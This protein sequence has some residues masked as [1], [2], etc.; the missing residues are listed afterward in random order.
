MQPSQQV[1]QFSRFVQERLHGFYGRFAFCSGFRRTIAIKM[2]G[3]AAQ[4]CCQKFYFF[5]TDSTVH[6]VH[7]QEFVRMM[8]RLLIK[9]R[10]TLCNP[11]DRHIIYRH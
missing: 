5:F 6:L 10:W 4:S 9:H 1:N 3:L 2:A 8:A 11:S 7:I